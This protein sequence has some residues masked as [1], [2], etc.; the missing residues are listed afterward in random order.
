LGIVLLSGTVDLLFDRGLPNFA[1]D[2]RQ[3]VSALL[4]DAIVVR[5][6]FDGQPRLCG[7]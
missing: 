3:L 4:S 6:G 5:L 2:S 7:P 1:D